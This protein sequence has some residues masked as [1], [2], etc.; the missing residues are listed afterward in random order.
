MVLVMVEVGANTVF[1]PVVTVVAEV[2]F[3]TFVTVV[4]A[5]LVGIDK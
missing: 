3:C 5:S 4:V 1:V 2:T